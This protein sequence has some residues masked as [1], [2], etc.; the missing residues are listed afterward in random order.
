M[1]GEAIFAKG[2]EAADRGDFTAAVELFQQAHTL[3]V[4]GALLN[5]GNAYWALEDLQH[6]DDAFR[7]GWLEG[8]EDAGFN[9]AVLLAGQGLTT[10]REV[11]RSLAANGYVKAALNE[12]LI[13]KDAGELEKAKTI[14]TPFVDHDATEMAAV[15]L[16]GS[17]HLKLGEEAE[18][19]PLLRRAMN[20]DPEARADYG[21][22]LARQHRM[23]EA[24]AVWEAGALNDET[25]SLIPLAN[26]ASSQG[27]SKRSA[28][29][30]RRAYELG[31]GH[32]ALNL[33]IDLWTEGNRQEAL[34]WARR[35]SRAGDVRATDW[36]ESLE[37]N[38]ED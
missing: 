25:E 35:A 6:A 9:L 24:Q 37:S 14:L 16:L 20:D 3:G 31:D 26:L 33:A 5:L 11:Y 12:A 22:L 27:D 7:K 8:D 17:I 23:D 21:R 34:V 38:H 28:E 2:N 29:L 18:A 19:E 32:A 15:G 4:P 36:L 10:A 13:L 30:N 1:D